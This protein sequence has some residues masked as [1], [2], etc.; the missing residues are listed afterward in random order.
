[1]KLGNHKATNTALDALKKPA[2]ATRKLQ[3]NIPEELHLAFK[4][5]CVEDGVD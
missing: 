5:A 1:M 2:G 3:M 4:L